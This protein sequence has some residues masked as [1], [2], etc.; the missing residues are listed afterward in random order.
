MK[1]LHITNDFS[2][3]AVYRNLFENLDSLGVEQIVYTPIRNEEQRNKNYIDFNIKGSQIQYRKILNKRDRLNY[4]GK[5]SKLF[6]DIEASVDF[7]DIFVVHAH[8]WFSDGGV[9]YELNKKYNIPYVLAIRSTDIIIFYKYLFFLRSYGLEIL[10]NASKIIFIS[11]VY[12]K[13]FKE[14]I[15][16]TSPEKNIIIPNGIDKFWINNCNVKIERKSDRF[17]LLYIGTFI[18]RKNVISLLKAVEVVRNSGVDCKLRLV[19]G[20][21]SEESK[22]LKY[23]RGKN[24][25]EFLGKITDK[26]ILL[27]IFRETDLFSMPSK[28]E[29]FGL[30]YIEALSQGI[31]IV[32]TVNEGIDGFYDHTIGEAAEYKDID[33]IANCILKIY[34]DY[35]KYDFDPQIIVDNHNWAEIAKKYLSIYRESIK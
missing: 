17:N 4:K 8:T 9:A 16:T 15:H 5:I 25:F 18:K 30:V 27:T 7:S 32:Y 3:S 1:I 31:P 10:K 13:K 19:G 33:D 21:G 22:I 34:N 24:H 11:K 23:I 35:E 14:I 20:G 28:S 2:G 26:E 6:R 29:T 12:E